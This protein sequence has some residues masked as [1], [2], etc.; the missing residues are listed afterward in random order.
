MRRGGWGAGGGTRTGRDFSG[1]AGAI[2]VLLGAW[3]AIVAGGCREIPPAIRQP[4]Q[5]SPLPI[6]WPA[7]AVYSAEPTAPANRWFQRAFG[8]PTSSIELLPAPPERPLP[9]AEPGVLADRAELAALVESAVDRSELALL[10]A[11]ARMLL[12]ADLLAAAGRWMAQ[13]PESQRMTLAR[14]TFAAAVSIRNAELARDAPVE[15]AWLP[16]PLREGGWHQLESELAPALQPRPFDYRATRVVYDATKGAHD[17]L[18]S[19][20]SPIPANDDAAETIASA[21][22][23]GATLPGGEPIA[24]AMLLRE[25]IVLDPSS[26]PMRSGTFSEAWLLERTPSGLETAVFLFDRARVRDGLDPWREKRGAD[27]VRIIDPESGEPREGAV[28]E[29]CGSCHT[30]EAPFRSVEGDPPVLV[31]FDSRPGEPVPEL[32]V[33]TESGAGTETGTGPG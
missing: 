13:A 25:R 30:E 6:G 3:V 14:I 24:R 32:P 8:D 5:Q 10:D 31:P 26:R 18:S 4:S 2:I 16:P 19:S 17:A 11:S 12:E 9:R 20:A 1:L 27:I 7:P 33:R 23:A 29:L 15:L 21:V 28:S 22:L